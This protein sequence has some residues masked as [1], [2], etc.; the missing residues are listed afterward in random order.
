MKELEKKYVYRRRA[1]VFFTVSALCGIFYADSLWLWILLLII[2]LIY[3]GFTYLIGKSNGQEALIE[4]V[5]H[6]YK[7]IAYP[8]NYYN[9]TETEIISSVESKLHPIYPNKSYLQLI[10]S[11]IPR[12]IYSLLA[13]VAFGS[14]LLSIYRILFSNDA[15]N[16]TTGILFSLDS[17]SKGALLDFLESFDLNIFELKEKTP[18]IR[19]FDFIVRSVAALIILRAITDLFKDIK[20]KYTYN[21]LLTKDHGK[22][23]DFF[24]QF[25]SKLLSW[26]RGIPDEHKKYVQPRW[27]IDKHIMPYLW[28]NDGLKIPQDYHSVYENLKHRTIG[29]DDIEFKILEAQLDFHSMRADIRNDLK[30]L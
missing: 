17:I 30:S 7:R 21:Q 9:M 24:L 14:A 23:A 15:L 25:H 5:I 16:L 11:Q 29:H 28:N 13:V 22:K 10:L 4:H 2:L 18:F 20:Q 12:V 19:I 8:L 6:R 27:I 1:L 3:I 26:E